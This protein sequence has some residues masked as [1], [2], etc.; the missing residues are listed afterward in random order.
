MDCAET[1]WVGRVEKY[2]LASRATPQQPID[3]AG[4]LQRQGTAQ[5]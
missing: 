4:K 5:L 2:F 1:A 3:G